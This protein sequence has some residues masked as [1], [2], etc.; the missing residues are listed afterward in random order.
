MTCVSLSF[1][2]FP[3]ALKAPL[4]GN[5]FQQLLVDVEVGV[6][7]LYVIVLFKGLHQPDHGVGRLPLELDVVLRN[8]R[9]GGGSGLNAGFLDRFENR[10]VRGGVG[11]NLPV[12]TVI[13]HV[14]RASVENQGHQVVFFGCD[15]GH[16]DVTLLVEHPGDG[17]GFGHVAAVLAEDVT[18]FADRAVAVVGVDLRQQGDT[19]GAVAFE[20]EFL[21]DGAGQ[22]TGSTLDGTLDVVGRH[23]LSLRGRDGGAQAGIGIGVSPAVLGGDGDFL[24]KA[25]ENL[26]PLG[27][28]SALFVLDGGPFG[29]AR[30]GNT[31]V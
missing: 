31:L 9:H 22:F 2:D 10:L 27:V 26:A 19:A 1:S 7:V 28:E 21:I 4:S 11:Q 6:D 23:V 16:D 17:T 30:H 20:H 13:A 12:V 5:F 3:A 24:D 8:H 18:D 25:S 29:M 14:L 15:F